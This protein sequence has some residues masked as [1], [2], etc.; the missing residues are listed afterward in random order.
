MAQLRWPTD[1]HTTNLTSFHDGPY[2][3]LATGPVR[4]KLPA[5]GIAHLVLLEA[6]SNATPDL[7]AGMLRDAIANATDFVAPPPATAD[8]PRTYWLDAMVITRDGHYLRVQL[9]SEVP[10]ARVI[11]EDFQGYFVY[12]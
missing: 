8:A 5:D 7:F 10:L 9:C 4:A 2:G 1:D 11:G 12:R 3:P 6:N